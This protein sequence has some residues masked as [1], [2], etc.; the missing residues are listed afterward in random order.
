M[1]KINNQNTCFDNEKYIKLQSAEIDERI[2]MFDNKLYLEFGGKIFDDLNVARILPGFRPGI[3]VEILRELKD[4]VEVIFCIN[5][6]AIEKKKMRADHGI[7]YEVELLR[8]VDKFKA[9]GIPTVAVVITLYTGQPAAEKFKNQLERRGIKTYIHTHTKGY[10]TDVDTI[11]SEEGYG[12]QSYI[13]TTKPLVVVAAPGPNSGK[14]ATCLSQLYHE[15]ERGVRAGYAKFE[16]LPVWNLPL[17]H[18]VNMEYEASTADIGDTNMIDDFY[19][20]K[21]GKMAVNYN[22]DLAVFPVLKKILH[23]IIGKDL[24]YS[25]T[26][27]SINV[28][29]E[30]I[31][32]DECVRRASCDEIIRRYLDSLCDY[33]NGFYDI[34][35]PNQIKVLMDELDIG[36]ADR[37]VVAA[38]LKKKTEK[39]A[40]AMAIELSDGQVVT[41]RYT[42]IMTASAAAVIN[43]IKNL[44][45][46][47]DEVHLIP[48]VN[49]QPMLKLKQEIYDEA[50]LYLSDVLMALAVS[51]ATNPTVE[52]ALSKL[53]ELKGLEAH[54]TIMLPKIEI[55]ALKKLGVNITCT[56]EFAE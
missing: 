48:P 45:N 11:V 47:D 28:I 7:S 46:I 12:A 56:D 18:P 5:A 53:P 10:P 36:V 23:K 20:E 26:D 30:C 50:R 39:K 21:Y 22:R 15:N 55:D 33:K 29:G 6:A 44:S 13:E 40:N 41:G 4:K 16:T 52:L 2:K 31:T 25:P 42:D 37:P 3:K 9:M 19:L 24:Y 14:L 17:K 8:L 49:G 38:A 51:A 35:V 1:Q 43:A 54:S 27:M 34:T 32:D